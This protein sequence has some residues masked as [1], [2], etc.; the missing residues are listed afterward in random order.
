[1][2]CLTNVSLAVTQSRVLEAGVKG[3]LG[4][5]GG[6]MKVLQ[7]HSVLWPPSLSP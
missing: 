4:T 7:Q 5:H 6:L 2:H 3:L 1:M